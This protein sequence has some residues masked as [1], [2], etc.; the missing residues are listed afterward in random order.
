MTHFSI[1]F[2]TVG[3]IEIGLL[4]FLSSLAPV[5]KRGFTFASFHEHG[6]LPVIKLL[7]TITNKLGAKTF[8][9]IFRIL[10]P[11]LSKP[12]DLFIFRFDKKFSTK[13]RVVNGML[14]FV[15]VGTFDWT[16]LLSNSLSDNVT[17]SFRFEATFTK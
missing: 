12:V 8:A 5:L 2:E 14:N 6:N 17:G 9:D 11:I 13:V 1:N 15:V 16:K 10:G 4:L 3:R 7:F